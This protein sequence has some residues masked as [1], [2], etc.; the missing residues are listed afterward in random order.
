MGQ[1]LLIPEL[2]PGCHRAGPRFR[3][4]S[5]PMLFPNHDF[6]AVPRRIEARQPLSQ[7]QRS[8]GNRGDDY[9]L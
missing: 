2:G 6:T 3:H 8:I 4:R 7:S 1:E 5:A 9:V